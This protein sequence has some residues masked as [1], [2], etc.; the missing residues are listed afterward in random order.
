[1]ANCEKRNNGRNM[2]IAI[3]GTGNLGSAL[4]RALQRARHTIVFGTRNPDPSDADQATI[5]EAAANAEAT[6]LAAPFGGGPGR[7]CRGRTLCRQDPDRRH[8]PTRYGFARFGADDGL[9]NVRCRNDCGH[10]AGRQAVQAFNQ[11][12]FEN[13]ADATAYATR[14]VT[15]V[16]EDDAAAKPLVMGLVTDAGFEPV[17]AGDMAESRLLEAYAMLW[18]ELP[19]KRGLGSDF[20]FTLQCKA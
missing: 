13:M 2:R 11:T 15:F 1:M 5:A 8:Q 6:I 14:P 4:A 16:A 20:T 17:D 19:R 18:I 10:G 9:F 12:G 7:D 3:I